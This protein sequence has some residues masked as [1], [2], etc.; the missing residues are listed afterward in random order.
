MS[1]PNGL[2]G[3]PHAIVTPYEVG[4]F[5]R[6]PSL[7]QQMKVG[8]LRS[9]LITSSSGQAKDVV[10]AVYQQRRTAPNGNPQIFMFIGG[11]LANADP[12]ASIASFTQ[13]FPGAKIVP[14]RAAGW[15]GNMHRGDHQWRERRDV[16]VV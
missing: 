13:S 12:A 2:S 8:Q 14:A 10:A 11:H 3:P 15:R 4:P 7:E 5:Q 16:R 1:F 9:D 6:E